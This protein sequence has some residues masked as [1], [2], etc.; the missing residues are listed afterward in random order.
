MIEL[1]DIRKA[2]N[3]GQPN[4][5]WA[6][7]GID[8]TIEANKVTAFRGPSGSGKTTLLRMLNALDEPT[9]G[10][11]RVA[12]RA[13]ADWNVVD[14]RRTVAMLFQMPTVFDGTVLDNLMMPLRLRD[15]AAAQS[16]PAWFENLLGS[17]G[18]DSSFLPRAA[19]D[20]SVGQQQ[21]ICFA[22]ALALRPQVVLL[23]EPTASL[24][25][26]TS[27]TFLHHLSG[28]TRE[29]GLTVVLVT[30]QLE[31]AREI[32]DR[33]MLLVDGEAVCT[34]PTAD[35]FAAPADERALRFQRGELEV[36]R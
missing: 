24:D 27:L 16:D 17:V 21:R 8:L 31:H 29:H 15:G 19:A 5:F 34:Q 25:P 12:G 14:L 32:A 4:E 6:L 33:V 35:F 26:T 2:F 30:H 7:N 28:F 3:Q 13:L 9:H 23:D 11:V 18:L 20:L 36:V 1:K 10:E 22:R